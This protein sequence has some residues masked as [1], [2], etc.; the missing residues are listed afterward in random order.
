MRPCEVGLHLSPPSGGRITE[1]WGMVSVRGGLV[2]GGWGVRWRRVSRV[3]KLFVLDVLTDEEVGQG[4][5]EE[6]NREYKDNCGY[7]P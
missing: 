1:P 2:R 5:D 3:V 4:T 7:K 6:G